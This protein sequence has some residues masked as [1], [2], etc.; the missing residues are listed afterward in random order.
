MSI[1]LDL[2]YA[3]G[4][5]VSCPVWGW[6]ILRTGKWRTDWGGRLGRADA[7][8]QAAERKRLLIHTVSVGETNLVRLLVEML[9]RERP[10]LDIVISATTNTGVA[11]AEQLYG[12]KHAIVRYPLDFS[13]AVKRFLDAV[14][15][16]AVALVENE[17]W[18]N[19]VEACERRAIPVC[20]INGRLTQRSH[21]RYA[22]L[23]PIVRRMYGRLAA[24]AA[25]TSEYAARF[26]DLGVPAERVHVLD[27]MKWDTA[28]VQDAATVAGAEELA[29]EMGIDRTRPL[30]VA[31]ST[32]PGEEELLI[33]TCPREA[34]LMLVPRKPE[35]FEE[36]AALDASIVRRTRPL[37]ARHSRLFLLDT[38]G[39]LRKAYAL[40][41]VC[42]VGRSFLRLYG[43]D[44]MEPV[45]LGKPTV[46]GPHHADFADAVAALRDAGG[47]IVTDEPGRVA[48]E[49][50]ADH[51]RAAELAR[52]GVKV[53]RSRQGST[54]RHADLLAQLLAAPASPLGSR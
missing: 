4:A 30:I 23:R 2:V 8:P 1:G 34:Q 36:V 53:I 22:M 6:Q 20:V 14:R 18:P 9:A 41:D 13:C 46:I 31:G 24:V 47:L 52:R 16:D 50:L 12:A 21:K 38:M 48:A 33:E 54:R 51:P 26:I 49:L 3:A 29:R 39:E 27:T 10:D 32:G 25:Q 44:I 7:K 15:P 35:R 17:V 11:R 45:A 28:Q 19:F 37:T 42:L 40:A 43:S 5:V